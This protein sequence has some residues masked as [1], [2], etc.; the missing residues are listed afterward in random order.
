MHRGNLVEQHRVLL[1]ILLNCT[2]GSKLFVLGG[3]G[4]EVIRCAARVDAVLFQGG[5]E[6]LH[7]EDGPLTTLFL[8]YVIRKRIRERGRERERVSILVSRAGG[9]GQK[10]A[11]S[12]PAAEGGC[13]ARTD[14]GFSCTGSC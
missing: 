4:L 14:L 8:L 12:R 2:G 9:R 5:R 3:S 7:R 13:L 1:L 11:R 6:V 10:K